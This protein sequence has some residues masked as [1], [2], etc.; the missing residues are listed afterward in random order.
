MNK[1]WTAWDISLLVLLI[2]ALG[3]LLFPFL[4]Q[5]INY[6]RIKRG[7][8]WDDANKVFDHRIY[9]TDYG[10]IDGKEYKYYTLSGPVFI[11]LKIAGKLFGKEWQ[12]SC[13]VGIQINS[14]KVIDKCY[15]PFND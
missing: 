3:L 5:G 15:D 14:R 1:K 4:V 12:Y 11:V 8:T 2:L 10:N 13:A 6:T 9:G 7:M